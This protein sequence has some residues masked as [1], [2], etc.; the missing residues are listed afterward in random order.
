M[1]KKHGRGKK[2]ETP[3]ELWEACVGYFEW[4]EDNPLLEDKVFVFQGESTHEHVTKMRAMTIGGLCLYLGM[5]REGW[6][7][8]RRR[9]GKDNGQDFS[10]VTHEAEEIIREQKFTGAAA[11]LLNANIIARDLGLQE[12]HNHEMT[13][14][15]GGP[16][17]TKD[18]SLTDIARRMAFVL[19]SAV[20]EQEKSNANDKEGQED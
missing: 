19:S 12:K 5:S 20:A 6:A 3:E 17:E 16:I 7:E 2:Y 11:D 14:K 8:Y 13:G 4:V 18:M 9:D 1:R 10:A 15:E